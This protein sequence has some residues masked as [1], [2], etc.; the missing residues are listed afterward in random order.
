[1][2]EKFGIDCINQFN[3]MFA[4]AIHDLKKKVVY[5]CRDRF[6]IKP[7]YFYQDSESFIFSSEIKGI[8]SCNFVKKNK[9]ERNKSILIYMEIHWVK[10]HYIK[11]LKNWNQGIF[12]KIDLT[13]ERHFK[14]I[15]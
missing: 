12:L 5:L 7:L 2:Y 11:V 9:Q 10:I 6:G 15:L 4:F 13:T 8:L 3:G 14:K 1:M